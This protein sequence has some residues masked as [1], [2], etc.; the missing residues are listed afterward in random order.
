[1]ED[2]GEEVDRRHVECRNTEVIRTSPRIL[3]HSRAVKHDRFGRTSKLGAEIGQS[4]SFTTSTARFCS[5]GTKAMECL[6]VEGMLVLLKR[7]KACRLD[8]EAE[9]RFISADVY[10]TSKL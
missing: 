10:Q 2:P 4:A 3:V 8:L 9:A 6:S 7:L 5:R 1:M